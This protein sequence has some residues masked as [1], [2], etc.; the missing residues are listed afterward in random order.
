M[1][2]DIV[3][4]E[5]DGRRSGLPNVPLHIKHDNNRDHRDIASHISNFKY[6]PTY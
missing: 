6:N 2:Y 1:R 5:H 4:I 3:I